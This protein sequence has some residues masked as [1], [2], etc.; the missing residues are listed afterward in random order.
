[1]GRSAQAGPVTADVL[2][3]ILLVGFVLVMTSVPLCG[4]SFRGLDRDMVRAPGWVAAPLAG[5][6]LLAVMDDTWVARTLFVGSLAAVG[7]F[8]GRNW[9]RPGVRLMAAGGALNLAAILSN[10]GVMPAWSWA[11]RVSGAPELTAGAFANARPDDAAPLLPLGDVVPFPA[12]LPGSAPFSIGDTLLLAGFAVLMHHVC[13]CAWAARRARRAG[14][15]S[16]WR[17]R[18]L[19]ATRA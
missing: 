8:L 14:T 15:A 11:W 3:V 9:D 7:V 19:R 2:C 10:G 5:Q 12:G 16:A 6:A 1:M 18:H 17:W 4:G 13:G